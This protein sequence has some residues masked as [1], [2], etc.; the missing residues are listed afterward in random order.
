MK[1]KKT[2]YHFII[3]KSGSMHGSETQTIAGFNTNLKTVQDLEIEFKEQEYAVYLTFFNDQVSPII[4]NS[5]ASSVN[6]L[7]PISYIPSGST[8]LLDAIGKSIYDIKSIYGPEI[9]QD[10]AS[11]VLI[12]ITDGQ[13][14]ASRF[15]TYHDIARM[16]KELDATERWTFSFLGADLDAIHTSKML[17]IRNENVMSFSKENYAGMM[18]NVSDSMREYS[19]TKAEGTTKKDIF[20]IFKNKDIRNKES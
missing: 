1:N 19:K 9:E 11:V 16:I 8:A 12:I 17:N 15:Y 13:E 4:Q 3:D 6:S 14:N 20:D 18:N 5:K 10:L 2:I 7:S